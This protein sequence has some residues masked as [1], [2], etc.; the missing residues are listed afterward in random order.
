[1]I[2]LCPHGPPNNYVSVSDTF[3]NHP[4][5]TRKAPKWAYFYKILKILKI[6]VTSG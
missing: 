1:M 4:T 2:G 5:P 3:Y 6:L